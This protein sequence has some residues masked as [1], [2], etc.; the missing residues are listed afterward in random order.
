MTIQTQALTNLNLERNYICNEGA[1]CLLN[2]LQNNSVSDILYWFPAFSRW[3]FTYRHSQ[4]WIL[5][6]TTLASKAD[7]ISQMHYKIIQWVT[8][9]YLFAAFPRWLLTHRHSQLWILDTTIFAMK[10]HGVSSMHYKI[11]QWVTFFIHLLHFHDDY[12]N[13]D[14][15][16]FESCSDRDWHW[17]RRVSR[18]CIT[19]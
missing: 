2:A 6:R 8:F 7:G 15:Y 9:F 4:L 18:K 12:S 14:T 1:Q 16:H 5:Q 10:A 11:I 19:K 3:L 13:T 17:R